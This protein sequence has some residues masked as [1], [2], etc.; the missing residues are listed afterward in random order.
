MD[1]GQLSNYEWLLISTAAGVFMVMCLLI[2]AVGGMLT[3]IVSAACEPHRRQRFEPRHKV[4]MLDENGVPDHT[5]TLSCK[6]MAGL[7][8]QLDGERRR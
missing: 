4:Q 6:G 2:G 3:E 5:Y 7:I 1:V 8:K